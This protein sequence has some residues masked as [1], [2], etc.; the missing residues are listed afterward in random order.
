MNYEEQVMG[1]GMREAART[2]RWR[3]RARAAG[4][5]LTIA[6]AAAIIS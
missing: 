6:P 2:A 3:I 4:F 1:L 5:I